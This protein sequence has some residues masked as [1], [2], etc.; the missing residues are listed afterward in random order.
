MSVQIVVGLLHHGAFRAIDG[1]ADLHAG[2]PRFIDVSSCSLRVS[3]TAALRV[4]AG[5]SCLS[6]SAETLKER[7][8]WG[9]LCLQAC[10]AVPT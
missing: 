1:D 8:R 3:R 2:P 6:A 4:E 7:L 5:I 10:S 9:R